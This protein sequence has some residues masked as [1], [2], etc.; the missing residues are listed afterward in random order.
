MKKSKIQSRVADGI[1]AGII[2]GGGYGSPPIQHQFRKGQSGN[3][4]GR[5][6]KS[7]QAE[8]S[9]M[10]N[11]PQ[12][13]RMLDVL[14]EPVTVNTTSGKRKISLG[15]ALQ[16][17]H[18]QLAL[19]EGR[20]YL[21]L[22]MKKEVRDNER[23]KLREI[24]EDQTEWRDYIKNFRIIER[25]AKEKGQPL[26]GFWILPE[27]IVFYENAKCRI[28]GATNEEGLPYFEILEKFLK[29]LI[30]ELTY[31]CCHYAVE[32]EALRAEIKYIA[33]FQKLVAVAAERQSN[34]YWDRLQ[35][36]HICSFWRTAQAERN[37]IWADF[38]LPIP[39]KRWLTPMSAKDR[40]T[41][42]CLRDPIRTR[43][44]ELTW[45]KWRYRQT[46]R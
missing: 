41:V 5:P 29:L 12:T 13:T 43:L 31:D 16:Q 46:Q 23:E 17:K 18:R 15:E 4:K 39:R 20:T 42:E 44:M 32:G 34:E 35:N 38:G 25:A 19:T 11:M 6:K 33:Y 10:A 36:D 22:Q 27:N 24:T 14:S 30:F 40:K 2:H 1:K 21:L 8:L 3:P 9:N 7:N 45:R 37:Q 26:E 28:R